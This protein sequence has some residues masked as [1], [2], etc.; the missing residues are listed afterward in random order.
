[1][2][3]NATQRVLLVEDEPGIAELVSQMLQDLSCQV[4][5]TAS[6]LDEAVTLAGTSDIDLAIL[7]VRL[8]G[9]PSEPVARVLQG[10]GIPFIFATGYRISEIEREFEAVPTLSKPFRSADLAHAITLVLDRPS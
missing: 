10:R 2:T 8:Q 7:D 6:S 4:V 1:M 5:A 3:I 9:Q